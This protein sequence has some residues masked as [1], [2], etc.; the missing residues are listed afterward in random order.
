M[1]QRLVLHRNIPFGT[2]TTVNTTTTFPAPYSV[3]YGGQRAQMLILASELT[4][5]GFVRG[6]QLTNIQFPVV[7]F[8]TNWPATV[9]ACNSFQVSVGTTNLTALTAFQSGLTQVVAPANF[10]P[11]VG[12]NNT[13]TFNTPIV[14][15]GTS[16]LI[17]E[18]TFSNQHWRYYSNI[19]YP[20]LYSNFVSKLY[21]I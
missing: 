5:A 7:S 16:N 18:T 3:Y 12:Y 10:T 21:L 2:Q 17:V 11:T 6:S 15:N 4:A 13:H 1:L 8:G 9:S 19:C 14:W 20:K